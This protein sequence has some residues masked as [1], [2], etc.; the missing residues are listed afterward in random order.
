MSNTPAFNIDFIGHYLSGYADGEGSFCISFSLRPK[1]RTSVEVRPSFSV[2]QNG[3][4]QEVL[5]LFKEFLECGTIRR[6]PSDRTFKYETRSID[7]L[8]SKIIPHFQ[9]YPLLS[10][11][12]KDFEKF[13]EICNKISRGKH[14]KKN[15]LREI[16]ELSYQ[17]NGFGARR[18]KKTEL[19][20]SIR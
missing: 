15:G 16:V 6:N 8:I 4:R 5:Y 10:S 19:L 18:Y 3:N 1:L 20:S 11:K 2:S 7:D 12:K 17:M 9:K 14:L 13:V